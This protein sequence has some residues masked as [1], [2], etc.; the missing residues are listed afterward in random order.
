MTVPSELFVL[1]GAQI[2]SKEAR[3]TRR[4]SLPQLRTFVRFV[5]LSKN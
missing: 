5:L 3:R 2:F 1:L 4:V